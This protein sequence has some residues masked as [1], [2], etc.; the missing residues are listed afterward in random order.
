MKIIKTGLLLSA[1]SVLLMNCKTVAQNSN[2]T[3]IS[4]SHTAGRGGASFITATQDSLEASAQGGR[5]ENFPTFKKKIA[6]K[7]WEK[8]VA[9]ID[10]TV[11]DKTKSGERR[12]VYDGPDQIFRITTKDK[13]YEIYNV[14]KEA[15]GYNQLEKLK[16][17]IN[18]LLPQYK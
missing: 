17:D 2:I 6:K 1:I 10:L 11:L 7:D 12:G 8:L 15:A 9:N 3:S 5:F 13:E 16:T 18:N 4:Y 14:A